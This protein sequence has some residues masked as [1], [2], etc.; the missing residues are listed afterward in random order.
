MLGVRH[1]RGAL[2]FKIFQLFA[3]FCRFDELLLGNQL[4]G[5]GFN[6]ERPR[7]KR[8]TVNDQGLKARNVKTFILCFY[9]I[10]SRHGLQYVTQV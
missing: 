1:V 9:A 2:N 3:F 4:K 6:G 7:R 5:R 10:Y 8:L